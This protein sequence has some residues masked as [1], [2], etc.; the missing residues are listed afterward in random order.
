LGKTPEEIDLLRRHS[1]D[2]LKPVGLPNSGA[3]L[4]WLSDVE[5]KEARA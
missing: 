1:K 5:A 3:M 2:F 4:Y